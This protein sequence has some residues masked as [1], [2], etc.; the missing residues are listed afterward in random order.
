MYPE[1]SIR[2]DLRRGIRRQVARR[3]CQ[4]GLGLPAAIFLLVV[5]ALLVVAMGDLLTL[6][7][8]VSVL[9]GNTQRA[10]LA[11]HSAVQAAAAE[12]LPAGQAARDCSAVP[13]SLAFTVDGLRGCVVRLQCRED[14]VASEVVFTVDTEASCGAGAEEAVQVLRWRSR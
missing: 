2:A 9:Q 10:T 11:A 5:L 8:Q 12:L 1:N 7:G 13:G 6:S 14:L 4:T 3:S